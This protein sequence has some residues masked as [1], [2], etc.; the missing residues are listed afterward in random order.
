[1]SG[2]VIRPAAF[3]AAPLNR[4]D[5]SGTPDWELPENGS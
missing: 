3:K 2:E 5:V 4:S 1:M